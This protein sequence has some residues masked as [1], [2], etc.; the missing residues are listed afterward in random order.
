MS[1]RRSRRLLLLGLVA[2]L[3]Y[4]YYKERPTFS[5]MIEGLTR[6]IFGSKAAVKESEYKRVVEEAEPAVVA[7]EEIPVGFIKENMK[8]EEVRRLLGDPARIEESQ[9]KGRIRVRWFYPRAKRVV[10]F[11]EGRVRWLTVL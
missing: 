4:W 11:E 3:G 1:F 6:P 8:Y 2:A 5:G 10:V 7:A 9:Q